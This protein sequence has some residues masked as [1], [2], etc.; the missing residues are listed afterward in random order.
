MDK[1]LFGLLVAFLIF[2]IFFSYF[3]GF[4]RSIVRLAFDASL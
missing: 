3:R 4:K 1:G 2:P